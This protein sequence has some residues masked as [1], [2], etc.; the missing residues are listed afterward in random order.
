MGN[1]R[2]NVY[3]KNLGCNNDDAKMTPRNQLWKHEI[4]LTINK[5]D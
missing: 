2:M 4:S 3:I 1:A 5:T